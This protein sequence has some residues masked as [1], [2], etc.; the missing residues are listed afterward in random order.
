M[1]L[2]IQ[3]G[4]KTNY[5]DAKSHIRHNNRLRKTRIYFTITDIM[6]ERTHKRVVLEKLIR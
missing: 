2:T 1:R 5:M 3:K 4:N 6:F